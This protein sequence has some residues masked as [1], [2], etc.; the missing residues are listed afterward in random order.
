MILEKN[1]FKKNLQEIEETGEWTYDEYEQFGEKRRDIIVMFADGN[2]ADISTETLTPC[3]SWKPCLGSPSCTKMCN[4]D[5]TIS[6]EC[7]EE[8]GIN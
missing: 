2:I 6:K 4:D 3:G 7:K 8:L 5:C 1:N